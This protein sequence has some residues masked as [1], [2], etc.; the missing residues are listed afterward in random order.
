MSFFLFVLRFYG[1]VN[2]SLQSDG[3]S[4]GATEAGLILL[5]IKYI[6]SNKKQI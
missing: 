6:L 5:G 2:P 1:P 3:A 4:N